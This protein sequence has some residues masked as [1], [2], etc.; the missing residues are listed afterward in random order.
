M[1]LVKW[2]ETVAQPGSSM[3]QTVTAESAAR[4]GELRDREPFTDT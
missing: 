1:K 2:S 4:E 3:V